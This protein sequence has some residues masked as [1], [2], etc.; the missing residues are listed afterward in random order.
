MIKTTI[1]K[2]ITGILVLFTLLTTTA[3]AQHDKLLE[4][5]RFSILAGLIQPLALKGYNVEINYFTSRM[6]FDYSHG[7]SL[8]P[9]SIGA[10]KKQGLTL[11]L[12][13]ST[14]FGVGYRINSFLDVRLEPK[15]HSWEVYFAEDTQTRL[16][17]LAQYKTFTLGVGCYYRYLPFRKSQNVFLRGIT[18]STSIRYWQNIGSTLSRDQF[19]FDNRVTE[20]QETLKAANIGIANTPIVFNVAIGYT[21]LGK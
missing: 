8:D 15:L 9:P 18:T 1:M 20:K 16:N 4:T 2:K 11:H 10:L 17:R 6:S 5:N 7:V 21:F 13:Y 12:P 14:G 19:S 3:V